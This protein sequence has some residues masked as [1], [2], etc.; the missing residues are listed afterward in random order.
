[1]EVERLMPVKREWMNNRRWER[2]TSRESDGEDRVD[3]E[4]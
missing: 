4:N 3:L 2:L 1:M